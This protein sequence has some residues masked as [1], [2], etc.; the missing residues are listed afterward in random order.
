MTVTPPA[1]QWRKFSLTTEQCG[2]DPR[3]RTLGP[4]EIVPRI[5]FAFSV[6]VSEKAQRTSPALA[7]IA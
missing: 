2:G 1:P 3:T 5:E 4:E 6:S 7:V